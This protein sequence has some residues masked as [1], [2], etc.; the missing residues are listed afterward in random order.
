[1]APECPRRANGLREPASSAAVPATERHIHQRAPAPST[2]CTFSFWTSTPSKQRVFIA[3]IAV[4]SGFFPRAKE[5]TP[6]VEQKRW[7]MTLLLNWYFVSVSSPES[8]LKFASGTNESN[9]PFLPHI[10]Q[11]QARTTP[12]KRARPRNEPGRS[13]NLPNRPLRST[14]D[15]I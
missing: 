3:V 5:V 8:N 7:S 4:P 2:C 14:L 6:H 13:D 12:L 1:M 15:R 9:V 10:E 11:L